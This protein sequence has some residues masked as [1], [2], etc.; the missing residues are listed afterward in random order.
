MPA[1]LPSCVRLPTQSLLVHL[2]C[3]LQGSG[4]ALQQHL[5]LILWSAPVRVSALRTGSSRGKS[6]QRRT[7]SRDGAVIQMPKPRTCITRLKST[8]ASRKV[9]ARQAAGLSLCHREP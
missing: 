8:A 3:S 4:L 7:Q 1:T 5:L 9:L 2:Q 6:K